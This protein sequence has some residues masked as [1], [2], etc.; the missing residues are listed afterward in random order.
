MTHVSC[1]EHFKTTR[2]TNWWQSNP[3]SCPQS[4][5]LLHA[6]NSYAVLTLSHAAATPVSPWAHEGLHPQSRLP[7]VQHCKKDLQKGV[8]SHD[9]GYP[10]LTWSERDFSS[11]HHLPQS[12]LDQLADS[13]EC[14]EHG[15][16][17]HCCVGI[18]GFSWTLRRRYLSA[19]LFLYP[20]PINFN[21]RHS[22]FPKVFLLVLL[23]NGTWGFRIWHHDI[24]VL[25]PS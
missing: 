8:G 4:I 21:K 25:L 14:S 1:S 18:S 11:N 6:S 5:P 22:W 3:A 10:G 9:L 13:R 17:L 2:N 23:S 12:A 19:P 16:F 24:Q 15:G 20:S 7:R